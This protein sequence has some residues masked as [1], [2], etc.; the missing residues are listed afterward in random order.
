M[1]IAMSGATPETAGLASGLINTSQQ[2]GGALGLA[3]LAALAAG[4]AGDLA[5]T[6]AAPAAALVA[7]FHLAW[8]VAA[9]LRPRRAG[10][11]RRRAARAAPGG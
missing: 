7:G 5:G 1:T 3:I 11:G 10:A 6:G 9:V 8:S 4:R 2:V